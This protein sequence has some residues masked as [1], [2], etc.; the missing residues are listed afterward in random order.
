MFFT[1]LGK[2]LV[3]ISLNVWN[4]VFFHSST[5]IWTQSGVVAMVT[6]RAQ[7]VSNSS[8]VPLYFYGIWDTRRFFSMFLPYPQILDF[9]ACLSKEDMSSY[10]LVFST[11]LHLLLGVYQAVG[12]WWWALLLS[13]STL[14]LRQALCSW[15]PHRNCLSYH[16]SPMLPVTLAVLCMKE[17]S[18]CP[19]VV[20]DFQLYMDRTWAQNRKLIL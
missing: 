20:R 12:G 2:L 7:V 17:F 15:L 14:C 18:S 13:R 16:D 10:A 9:S 11:V 5:S 8:S 4:V 1:I 6:V 19:L 3:I